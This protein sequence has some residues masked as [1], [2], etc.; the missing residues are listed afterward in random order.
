MFCVSNLLQNVLIASLSPISVKIADFGVSKREIDTQLRTH[1][2]TPE[3][4]APEQHG[5]LPREL[6]ARKSYTNAADLWALG[7]LVHE[8]LTSEIPFLYREVDFGTIVSGLELEETAQA[9]DQTLLYEYCYGI[10]EFPTA[11]LDKSVIGKEGIDFVKRLLVVD[12]KCRPSASDALKSPWL[13]ELNDSETLRNRVSYL[14]VQISLETADHL[15]AQ[16]NGRYIEDSM[17]KGIKAILNSSDNESS[18]YLPLAKS[19]GDIGFEMVKLLLGREVRVIGDGAVGSMWAAAA[20]GSFEVVKL[21]L[22][23]GINVNAR[24][25]LNEGTQP[26]HSQSALHAAVEGGHH[27]VAQLLLHR[28]ANANFMPTS[29]QD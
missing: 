3:Y 4:R 28:G 13:L 8:I 7:C 25:C 10:S 14:G 1:C 21:L 19:L 11:S 9:L 15:I 27:N 18:G 29:D 6:T 16:E 12:P 2:G 26:K 5:F 22:D 17:G 24:V 23:R 20:S